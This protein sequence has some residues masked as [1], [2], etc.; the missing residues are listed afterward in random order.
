MSLKNRFSQYL[1]DIKETLE[2][3]KATSEL[4]PMEE[5]FLKA[6]QEGSIDL[7]PSERVSQLEPF[8]NRVLELLG[9][10]DAWVSDMA[11]VDTF[12]NHGEE[13]EVVTARLSVALGFHVEPTDT[14]VQVAEKLRLTVSS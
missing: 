4:D 10:P 9:E 2:A 13:P 1:E 5:T 3:K 11:T 12:F 8:V 6:L 14:I 7:G